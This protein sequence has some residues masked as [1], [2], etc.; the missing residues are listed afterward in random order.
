MGLVVSIQNI[1]QKEM[2]PLNTAMA[3]HP[4]QCYTMGW[5]ICTTTV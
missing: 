5:G 4:P 3:M 1:Q 2:E